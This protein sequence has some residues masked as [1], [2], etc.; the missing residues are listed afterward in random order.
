MNM[1]LKCLISL[2][3]GGLCLY[4]A[5][6]ISKDQQAVVYFLYLVAFV[7]FYIGMRDLMSIF[8]SKK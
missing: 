8:K 1:Y 2:G 3:L 7:N 4:L 6:T 5:T